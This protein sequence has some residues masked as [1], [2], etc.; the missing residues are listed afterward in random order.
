MGEKVVKGAFVIGSVNMDVTLPAERLPKEGETLLA[1]ES[2]W[3]PGGKGANQAVALIRMGVPTAFVG[4]VGTDPFGPALREALDREGLD[5][6]QLETAQD[7]PSG[8][9]VIIQTAGGES[10]ILVAPGANSRVDEAFIE[11]LPDALFRRQ[12]LA[13]QLEIPHAGAQ[14]AMKRARAAGALVFLD[15]SPDKGV[16]PQLIALADVV[17]PNRLEASHL[18]G[19]EVGDQASA[20]LAG[21]ALLAMGVRVAIVKLGKDGAVL[22]QK[23]GTHFIPPSPAVAVDATAAGDAFLGGLLAAHLRGHDFQ[24]AA[25]VGAQV[26]AIAVSRPGAMASL[27]YLQEVPALR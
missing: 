21:Q 13:I 5:L 16:D 9:A 4:Q 14:A 22:V 17:T 20:I 23:E 24:S 6:S 19:I 26:A 15:P 27:P 12:A 10:T 7:T 25:H 18:T 3:G 2:R 11:S 1:G 8:L